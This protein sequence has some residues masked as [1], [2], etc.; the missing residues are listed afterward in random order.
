MP[1]CHLLFRWEAQNAS[2]HLCHGRAIADETVDVRFEP[3]HFDQKPVPR[4]CQF[5]MGVQDMALA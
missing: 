1:D 2:Q 4:L 3:A 5:A